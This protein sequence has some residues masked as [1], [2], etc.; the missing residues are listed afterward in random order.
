MY[1]IFHLI[2]KKIKKHAHY[3]TYTLKHLK[4]LLC[5][6]LSKLLSTPEKKYS[7]Y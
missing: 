4:D 3:E 7:D 6:T 2:Q 5:N 1:I